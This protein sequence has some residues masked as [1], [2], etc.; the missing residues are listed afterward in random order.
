MDFLK[1]L[2]NEELDGDGEIIIAGAVFQRSRILFE[3]EPETYESAF[4]EWRAQRKERSLK[5]LR[6]YLRS[7]ITEVD[8]NV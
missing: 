2:F 4:L 8:S 7:T 1:L 3:L 6:K 5:Q